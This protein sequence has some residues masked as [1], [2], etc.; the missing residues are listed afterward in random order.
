MRNSKSAC[1]FTY[2]YPLEVGFW[3]YFLF[4]I[5]CLPIIVNNNNKY[6]YWKFINAKFEISMLVYLCIPVGSWL[7]GL[8]SIFN[9]LFTY[10][11]KQQQ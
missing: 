8:F 10:H 5:L 4:L 6:S 2:V 11:C 1:L 3:V 9:T 7:L